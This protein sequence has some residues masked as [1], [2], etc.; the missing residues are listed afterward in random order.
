MDSGTHY[1]VRNIHYGLNTQKSNQDGPHKHRSKFNQ[2]PLTKRV[3]KVHHQI[4]RTLDIDTREMAKTY[5]KLFQAVHHTSVMDQAIATG[6]P[7]VGMLR[8]VKKLSSFIRPAGPTEEIRKKINANTDLWMKDNL[9]TLREHYQQ[10][11]LELSKLP[12]NDLAFQVAA[13]WTLKRYGGRLSPNTNKTV[14]AILTIPPPDDTTHSSIPVSMSD[15]FSD[16]ELQEDPPATSGGLDLESRDQFPP[17]PES[18]IALH[19]VFTDCNPSTQ[20]IQYKSTSKQQESTS[21]HNQSDLIQSDRVIHTSS[22]IVEETGPC[23]AYFPPPAAAPHFSFLNHPSPQVSFREQIS[24][25]GRIIPSSCRSS[26]SVN[27]GYNSR[28]KNSSQGDKTLKSKVCSTMTLSNVAT[29]ISDDI[30]ELPSTPIDSCPPDGLPM[31]RVLPERNQQITSCGQN[32]LSHNVKEVGGFNMMKGGKNIQVKQ[33]GEK[34]R[35]DSSTNTSRTE[36]HGP[37]EQSSLGRAMGSGGE[38]SLSGDN[39]NNTLLYFPIC[40]KARPFRKI[41]DWEI[42]AT[43][44]VL[45]LG[46]SNLDKITHHSHSDIQIHSYPGATIYHFWKL[47]QKTPPHPSVQVVIFSV[48]LNNRDQDPLKTSIKQL[49]S[50]YRTATSTFPNAEL[51]FPLINYSLSLSQEQKHNLATI[52]KFITNHL[53]SLPAISQEN[54]L[55]TVDNIHWTTAT[56]DNIFN[57]WCEKLNF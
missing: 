31:Q 4:R 49:R 9:F 32:I 21:S 53:P 3:N 13:D 23:V 16:S 27:T 10:I 18:N 19:T 40:H 7:P 42:T 51:F 46:D 6:V 38:S 20:Q 1:R 29:L 17:L 52:N 15:S 57:W 55:T 30:T 48:G 45:M 44:P 8:Q 12:L 47:L 25:P 50:L 54:F 26:P 43:K 34:P 37:S 41:Q 35:P 36:M 56:A 33:T 5:F 22:P 28:I 2:P 24:S 14:K 11:I 39:Q